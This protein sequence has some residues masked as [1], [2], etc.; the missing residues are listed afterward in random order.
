MLLTYTD[1]ALKKKA[2][3]DYNE[4]KRIGYFPEYISDNP[5]LSRSEIAM[6]AAEE[7]M[8]VEDFTKYLDYMLEYC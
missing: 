1:E 5:Y 6:F 2:M 7:D 3:E 8:T 4:F